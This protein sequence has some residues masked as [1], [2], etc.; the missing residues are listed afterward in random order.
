MAAPA[1]LPTTS[2]LYDPAPPI[3]TRTASSHHTHTH[4]HDSHTDNDAHTDLDTDVEKQSA[5]D[6]HEA[7]DVR[8]TLDRSDS[9]FKYPSMKKALVIMIGLYC[10]IFIVAL[11]R[12]ILGVAIP[13]IT[14]EFNSFS[15]IGW[16]QSACEYGS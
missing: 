10:A 15:D 9:E 8:P 6:V 5:Q 11:D 12:T 1:P 16:Y 13:K 2:D 3:A 4:S 14:D 7:K